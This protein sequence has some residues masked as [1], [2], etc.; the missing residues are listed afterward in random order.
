[1]DLLIDDVRDFNVDAIARTADAAK[2]MLRIGGWDK[3]FFDHDL[4]SDVTGYDILVYALENEFL[5]KSKIVF[6]TSNPVGRERME[7]A[8]KEHN[9]VVVRPNPYSYYWAKEDSQ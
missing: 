4:G 7:S 6:V 1:M 2:K 3:I 9:F 5:N 8:L